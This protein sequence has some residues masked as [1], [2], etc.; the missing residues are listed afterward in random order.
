MDQAARGAAAL[1]EGRYAEAVIQ[2]NIAITRSPGA[3]DY[4]IKRSTAQQRSS[5][6]DY[7]AALHDAEIAVNFAT[8]RAKRELIGQ[9]QLRRGIALFGLGRYA[10]AGHCFALAKRYNEKESSLLIWEKKVEVKL[11][12]L[13]E[14]AEA[15]EV[16][17]A[18]VPDVKLPPP[19]VEK[20]QG[21]RDPKVEEISQKTTPD[22]KA[23]VGAD[24]VQTP[25][26]KIRHEW[27]QTADTVTIEL[28]AK[29]VAKD[30]KEK[31]VDIEEQSVIPT[32]TL[33]QAAAHDCPGF[34]LFPVGYGIRVQSHLRSAI[35]THRYRALQL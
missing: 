29:G 30:S 16:T 21:R 25:A 15:R 34:N 8:Q 19:P 27:F 11:K 7:N 18:D 17:I 9:A 2:Y 4:Y 6:P 28:F 22:S 26:N 3:V 32:Q 1:K 23:N 12:E 14:G 35:F 5:P 20:L 13:D 33:S 24:I 10:D 31:I